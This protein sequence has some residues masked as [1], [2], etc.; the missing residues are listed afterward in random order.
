M[1][2]EFRQ[3]VIEALRRDE[4]L[5][6][7]WARELFPPDKREYELV[8]HGKER[9]EDILADTIA[10]PLQPVSTFGKNGDDWHN[11]L[12]FGDNLQAMKTL[13][14]MKEQGQLLNADG[15]PGVRLVY[16]DPPFATRQ[17]FRGTQDQ[18]AYQDKIAG[19]KFIEFLRARLVLIRELLAEN[20]AVFVHL[21]TRKSHYLKI[22]L[23][24][25]FQEQNFRNEIVWKRQ[26][27]HSDAHQCGAIHD[28]IF[29]YSKSSDWVWNTVRTEVSAEY[30]QFFDQ[31]EEGTGR[32]Y[33]RADLTAAGVTKDGASGRPWRRID[34]SKKGRHWAYSPGVL[35][36]LDAEGHIHWPQKG[37]P[38]LKRY[39][40]E[41]EG[42]T[43]QD[44]WTD[45]KLIHNQS[46]ERVWYP[47]QKPE[48]VAERIVLACSNPG[49]IV[50]D[51]FAGSGTT[52]AVAEK[53]RR[54]WIGIDCGKLAIYT[55][56]KRMLNLKSEIGSKGKQLN[57]RPFTLYNAGLYDFTTL[58]Q[59]P[60]EGWRFFALQLFGC[61]DEPHTIGGLKLDGKLKGA[62]VLVFDHH[63]HP[64]RRI[65]EDTV[66]DIHTA[67]GKKIGRKFYI[68]A[69]R[70]A[71]DFQQDYID[72][73]GVSYYA[74]R[75][76]YSVISELH[77]RE[78]TALQQPNDET[79]VNDTVD[80][81]GFDFIQPPRV[82][83]VVS[84]RRRKARLM[85]EACLK[86]KSFESRARLHGKDTRGG[87]ETFSML[88]LDYDYNGEVFDLD[89]VFYA[90]QLEAD[91]WQ[92]WLPMVDRGQSIMA[93]FIDIYGNEARELIP[94]DKFGLGPARSATKKSS[95][96]SRK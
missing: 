91:D 44:V 84:V 57:S 56:Q 27:A 88:M 7:E 54:R 43:L 4:D 41:V 39:Q 63:A 13:L 93:V 26:S 83:W 24:E 11:M 76:P 28:T 50:L 12:I 74:L 69:P 35:D 1:N 40:D 19:A 42:V 22:V 59:L 45:I 71:F 61:K 95:K 9:E 36:K 70:G 72:L 62:S 90:H 18:R 67:V 73:D 78:F 94:R 47:T 53:L 85:D 80:A 81:V 10:V 38:R 55:I 16:I 37:M 6:V 65:D 87:M 58:R 33:S 32:R 17:E 68:I 25:I 89:A 82:E 31:I 92:V 46:P 52:L 29:F 60:R 79:A 75:I 48:A 8:Y 5:P 20:G 23:D 64:G 30:A 15:T 14:K 49:D 34:P 66:R 77:H 3:M 51:A 21:D 86:V 2:D 96:R